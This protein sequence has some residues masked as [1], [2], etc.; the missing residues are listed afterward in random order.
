MVSSLVPQK[1][2]EARKG[3]ASLR[4]LK[5]V[6]ERTANIFYVAQR[7][8]PLV[9]ITRKTSLILNVIKVKVTYRITM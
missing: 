7:R 2:H 1:H 6:N 5:K 4:R 8:K 3:L 9:L